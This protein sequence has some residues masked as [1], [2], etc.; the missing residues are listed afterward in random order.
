VL[1]SYDIACTSYADANTA[2]LVKGFLNY[3]VS[4][5]GQQAAASAAGSAPISQDLFTKAQAAVDTIKA[6]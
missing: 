6:G 5:A 4:E 3:A 2:A 1:V